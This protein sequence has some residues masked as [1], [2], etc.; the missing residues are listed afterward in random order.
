MNILV[1]NSGSSSVKYQLFDMGREE[2]L[3]VKGMADRIGLDDSYIRSESPGE[4]QERAN[5]FLPDHRSALK[6]VFG[7]LQQTGEGTRDIH[8]VGHRVVHGGEAFSASVLVDEQV[9]RVLRQNAELAPLH[10]PPNLLGIEVC[11][12][13][14]PGVP[15]VAV[16]DTALHQ[17]LPPKAYL[18][19]LPLELYR[20]HGIRKYGFHG[21]SHIYVAGEAAKRLG[22]PLEDLKIVTCHLGNGCSITAFAGGKSIDTSMGFTPLEGLVMGT[23]S[24]DLDPAVALYLVKE[25]GMSADEAEDLLN[26]ESGLKGLCGE[27]DMRDVIARAQ[28][29]NEAAQTAIEVF[30]YRIQKYIGA[31]TAALEGLDV[32]VFTAGIGENSAYIRERVLKPFAYLGLTVDSR[33]NEEGRT[34]FSSPDSAIYAMTIPTDEELVIARD[35]YEIIMRHT[36]AAEERQGL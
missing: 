16:F 20:T 11:R 24:G 17:T 9:M 27:R 23:R 35:A 36:H 2:R 1:V 30:V 7:T 25:L 4:G 5:A 26:Q 19:G 3:L 15:N 21:T 10:N 18:Y 29:G 33:R 14:L 8:G 13:L 22:R 32:V 6:A 12:A 34:I 28:Q 31:Y